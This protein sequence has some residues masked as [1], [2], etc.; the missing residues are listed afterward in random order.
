MARKLHDDALGVAG[1]AT[2]I[3][4][5]VTVTG[6]LD[7]ESDITIDGAMH[8][9]ITSLGNLTV[10]VNANLKS[11]IKAV[12]VVI[13]GN[14]TGNISASGQVTILATGSVRGNIT[15]GGLAIEQGGIFIGA[16]R[17]S[18]VANDHSVEQKT[19]Q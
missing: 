8:G 15:S 11:N 1:A 5:G 12:E 16:S 14:L 2:V 3:G 7:A 10:G 19:T 9:D 4:A 13:G 17:Q 18:A 6:T